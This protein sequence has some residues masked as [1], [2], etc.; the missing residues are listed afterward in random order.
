[1]ANELETQADQALT[2]PVDTVAPWTIKSVPTEIRNLAISAARKEGL[3]VS[4]WLERR[5]REWTN[6]FAQVGNLS[7]HVSTTVLDAALQAAEVARRVADIPGLPKSVLRLSH[8]VLRERLKQA[9]A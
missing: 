5:V 3:T 6:E 2:G 8:G 4:Q 7:A 1:M 9:R